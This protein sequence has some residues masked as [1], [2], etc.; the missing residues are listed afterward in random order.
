MGDRVV[1]WGL[2]TVA[3]LVSMVT[4][5]TSRRILDVITVPT[6]LIALSYRLFE[7]GVGDLEGGFVSGLV[8]AVG[9]AGFFSIVALRGNMGW[10]DV[11][12]LFA[13]GAVFGYPLAMSATLFISLVGFLLALVT[14]IWKGTVWTTVRSA[15]LRFTKRKTTS[16]EPNYIPYGVAIALGSFWAMW[17]ER[18]QQ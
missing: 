15:L 14:L 12:L 11:K 1:L 17:W 2:L 9:C 10:G 6:A 16:E 5:L 18:T 4:D 3:L 13:V 8:A 7:Q